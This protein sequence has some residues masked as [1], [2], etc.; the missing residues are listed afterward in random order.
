MKPTPPAFLYLLAGISIV[1]SG[2][3]VNHQFPRLGLQPNGNFIVSSGQEIE[4]GTI[5]FDGRPA[6]FALNP[7]QELLA[8][9]TNK[10]VFICTRNG[11]QARTHSSLPKDSGAGY[12]GVIWTGDRRGTNW[13]PDGGRFIVSTDQGYLQEYLFEDHE[14]QPREKIWLV[15]EAN[16]KQVWPGGMCITKDGKRLFVAVAD[17]NAVAEIDI[18]THKKVREYPV[19]RIPFECRLSDDEKTLIVSNWGGRTP[20]PGDRVGQTGSQDI[21]IDDRGTPATGT[22]SIVD[23]AGG[24]TTNI[25]VGIHPNSILIDGNHAYVANGMS[26][27]ISDINLGTKKV[28]R[29]IPILFQSQKVLGAMPNA[30][31]KRG[32]TLLVCDGGDNALAEID[33]SSGKVLGYRPAGYFPC[34]LQ[35]SADGHTA[36]VLNSKGNGSV[37]NTIVGNPG[38]PHDFQGTISVINLNANLGAATKR[39]AELNH[40]NRDTKSDAKKLAVY[41]GAIQHV[42]YIIKEN[43]TYDSIFG[44][45]PEGNGDPKLCVLGNRVMPNHR[46]IARDFTLF[47][48]GYVSGTNSADGHS[49]STQAMAN[50]YM[51]HEYVGYR[52]YPDDGDCAMSLSSSGGLWDAALKKGKTVRVYGEFCDDRLATFEPREPKDWFE[53]WE[54]RQ[55]GRNLFKYHTDTRVPSLKPIICRDLHYWPIIQSDQSRAD[56]FLREY[57]EF[58]KKDQVPNLM[59]LTLTNDHGSGMDPNFPTPAAMAADNDL[60]LGRVVEAVSKSPQWK[61]TAIFVIEDDG[62]ALPDHVDGHRT[63]YFVISPY[64]RRRTVDHN[65]YTTVDMIKSMEVMLGIEPMNRFDWLARPITT[66]FQPQ[67]DLSPYEHCPN[68]Q[69]LDERNAPMAKLDKVGQEFLR[70]SL[71][72]DWSHIDGPDPEKLSRIN[73]YTMTKGKPYPEQFAVRKDRDDE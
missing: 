60:A 27:T 6:D 36:F 22:V 35:L 11:V 14:I 68:I 53:A 61:N 25:P 37:A 62:Q 31:A 47:D 49:W 2:F 10:Q 50:D 16:P 38:N 24:A 9:M 56:V 40:W 21:V 39:V 33:L 59:I 73:W 71:S 64:N 54:D 45:M 65:L 8:V 23:L 51:E 1:L 28:D 17:L 57:D 19:E 55:S 18:A 34:A 72:L 26:D 3:A 32:N 12:R 13:T 46:K 41:N 52:T 29:E 66:C 7:N 20:R 63:P 67:P 44:D 70:T 58:S 30:L 43:Q 48:N 15:D 42:L 4:P 69:A 5:P